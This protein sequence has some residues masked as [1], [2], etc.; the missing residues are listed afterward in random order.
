MGGHGHALE[1]LK[2]TGHR[3]TPQRLLVLEAIAEGGGHMGAEEVLARVQKVYP[4]MDISTVY[5]VLGLLEDLGLVTHI[6]TPE[7]TRYELVRG[8]ERHHH[9]VC[10]ACG[11]TWDM[12]TRF[13]ADLGEAVWKEYRFRAD[14]A[15]FTLQ[16]ICKDC[17]SADNNPMSGGETP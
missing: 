3:L 2:E 6:T 16:G 8:G 15:H 10:R 4:Y 11:R 12:S 14:M 13:L 17:L 7:G 5:R 9:M 1:T